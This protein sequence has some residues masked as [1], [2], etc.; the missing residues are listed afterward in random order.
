M[1]KQNVCRFFG[2]IDRGSDG[3]RRPLEVG[4]YDDAVGMIG[5]DVVR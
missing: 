3:R 2:D 1:L 4:R 5:V